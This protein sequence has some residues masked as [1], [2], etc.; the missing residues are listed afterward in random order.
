MTRPPGLTVAIGRRLSW[1]VL[2]A[3]GSL[4]SQA[5]SEEFVGLTEPVHDVDL[6]FPVD[7]VT[8]DILVKEGQRV[9]KG[10]A[11]LRLDARIQQLEV[12]R[13]GLM[14]ADRGRLDA[15]IKSRVIV[16]AM[17]DSSR[18]LFKENQSVS[19]DEVRKL[20]LECC[21]L[22][23]EIA[24]MDK[25]LQ[26]EKVELH[27]AQTEFERRTL[28]SPVDG[29]VTEI[30]LETGEW[31]A[32]GRTVAH[33]ADTS[34]CHLEVSLD[35]ARARSLKAGDRIP[36]EVNAGAAKVLREGKLDFVSPVA[37]PASGLVRIKISFD[38]QDGRIYPGMSARITLEDAGENHRR[39]S[40]AEARGP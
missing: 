25:D 13:R 17:L 7:G 6:A 3:A 30:K 39:E 32:A 8:A 20:E 36:V 24:A 26:R 11:L 19:E 14:A 38:N 29:V 22:D 9:K 5:R 27:M 31:A 2:L 34:H 15:A 1:L 16:G 10:A 18:R 23:G 40:G 33:V 28:A 12:E 21:R 4:P 37:D 35:E